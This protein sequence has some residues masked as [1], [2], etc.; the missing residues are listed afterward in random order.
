MVKNDDIM[1]VLKCLMVVTDG[2]TSNIDAIT[3]EMMT[4]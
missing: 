1:A 3:T 4:K 2:K